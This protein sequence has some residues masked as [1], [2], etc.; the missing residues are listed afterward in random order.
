VP[1]TI[2]RPGQQTLVCEGVEERDF[3][4]VNGKGDRPERGEML[5]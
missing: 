1:W 4:V 2:V 3:V 5:E